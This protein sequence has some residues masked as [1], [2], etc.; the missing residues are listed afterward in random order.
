MMAG[1]DLEINKYK[2]NLINTSSMI[3][4]NKCKLKNNIS[5]YFALKVRSAVDEDFAGDG[6]KNHGDHPLR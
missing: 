3:N 1:Q 4:K 2:L 6:P 5:F